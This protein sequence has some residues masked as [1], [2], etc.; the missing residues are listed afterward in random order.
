LF[1][2]KPINAALTKLLFFPFIFFSLSIAG[3]EPSPAKFGKISAAD[4][5]TK[6]YNIDHS[7]AAVVIADIG[8]SRVVGSLRGW[9]SIEFKRFKR[10]HILKKSAFD[11]ANAEVLLYMDAAGEEK[12]KDLKAHT[13]NLENGKVVETKVDVKKSTYTSVFD[14]N[15]IVKKFV[16]PAVREGSVIEYE[17]TVSSDFIFNLQPWRFQGNYPVLW[18]EY[19]VSIPE[20]LYYVFF[21]QGDFKKTQTTTQENFRVTDTRTIAKPA[22][23]SFTATVN[24][25]QMIMKNVPAMK[26]ESFVSSPENH[27]AKI[28]F[29]LAEYR[30]PLSFQTVMGEWTDV[31]ETLLNDE[32][33]AGQLKKDNGWLNDELK[34]ILEGVTTD[35]EKAREIFRHLQ[36]NFTCTSHDRLYTEQPLRN[37]FKNRSGSVAEI[38]LLLVAM[39]RKTGLTADPLMLSTKSHGWAFSNYPIIDRFNYVICRAMINDKPL[40]LDA[41]RPNLGFG[42]LHWEC[43]N[44]HARV[45][46]EEAGAVNLSSDSLT[47]T[48][49]TTLLLYSNERGEIVGNVQQTPGY[50]ESL[51]I[52]DKVKELGLKEYLKEVENDKPSDIEIR[53]YRSQHL[54]NPD[55]QLQIS[56]DVKLNTEK[57]DVI[58][59]DPMFGEGFTENPFAAEQR[60]HP[61]EMPYTLDET[62]IARIELPKDYKAQEIPKSGRMSLDQEGK[63]FFEY[64]VENSGGVISLRSR[65]KVHRSYFLPEE[66][67]LL[68]DFFSLVVNKQNEKIVLKKI[69]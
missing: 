20:F 1:K 11:L 2:L 22:T 5:K 60:T 40:Y 29:Q 38:N 39:L 47:E 15:H 51:S 45:I 8:S 31:I 4:L 35:E 26:T 9:F 3:Q 69:K 30:S 21:Q 50:Y 53:N 24:D 37:V 33:F 16:L 64:L 58:Y 52:R 54:E 27:I 32:N 42:R 25:Y 17:Y 49:V 34:N 67:K 56:Y 23:E 28:E 61:V 63:S 66:Y 13:Y 68:R 41:S 46:N 48:R 7:A 65:V 43:Y 57:K 6:S 59:L 44:G 18:S 10:I 14:K 19:N 62:F 12:L 36:K 55:E